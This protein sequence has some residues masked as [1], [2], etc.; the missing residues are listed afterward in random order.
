[1][2][3]NFIF[4][5][6]VEEELAFEAPEVRVSAREVAARAAKDFPA[7]LELFIQ[8]WGLDR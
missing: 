1:M 4:D 6:F 5:D 2:F 3:G 8:K 7:K